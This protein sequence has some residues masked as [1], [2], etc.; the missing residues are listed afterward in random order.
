MNSRTLVRDHD[1]AVTQ[2]TC[3]LSSWHKCSVINLHHVCPKSW[4]E[5]AGKPVVTPMAAICP[6]CHAN[7]HAALDAL[8]SGES[9]KH[10][11][12]KCVTLARQGLQIA[13]QNDLT[14]APTL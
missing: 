1:G 5:A 3:R 6:N 10:L 9:V 8:I 2:Q 11:P 14:P 12:R 7:T 4:F 13:E